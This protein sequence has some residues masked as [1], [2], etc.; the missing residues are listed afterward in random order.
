LER[1]LSQLPSDETETEGGDFYFSTQ[2]LHLA[3]PG[4]VGRTDDQ[5][6]APWAPSGG[7]GDSNND[8]SDTK[9]RQASRLWQLQVLAK[10]ERK[11]MQ[12]LQTRAKL[13]TSVAQRNHH[14]Q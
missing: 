10:V 8:S 12:L 1:P 14:I 11:Q 13:L 4:T 2:P 5:R 6:P 9:Q 3:G 7:A